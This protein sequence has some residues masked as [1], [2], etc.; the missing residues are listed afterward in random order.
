MNKILG[1]TILISA[2]LATTA[3]AQTPY[4]EGQKAL[5]EQNWPVA[6]EQFQ[7]A[8]KA[9]KSNADAAMYWRAHA[10]YQA[11]RKAEAERQIVA[12]ERKYPD[13][14]WIKQAQVLQIENQ[15]ADAIA[16]K[17]AGDSGLD[18][19]LR[20]FAL[21]QLMDR[22]PERAIPLVLK[23]LRTT[24]NEEIANDALFVLGM[25]DEP[26]AQ[27]AI[28]EVAHDSS[29]P[30]LQANAIHILGA[31]ST[32][33]SLELL[34]SL[35]SDSASFEVKQSIIQAHIVADE[36]GFLVEMLK[37]E[38]DAE[39]QREMIHALGIMDAT[40]QLAELYPTLT[41]METRRAALEAFS[42]A[43]DTEML[44]QVLATESE[45]E[46]RKA[47]IQGL[48]MEGGSESADYL[49]S[50]YANAKS[51]E[52][53]VDILES[54][55]MMDAAESFALSVVRTETDPE[56]QRHAI[57]VLGI[58][59]ATDELA[60]LYVN[61]TDKGS[62]IAV[63]ESMGISD[64]SRG[65][66]KILE[67]EKDPELREAAIQGL[68]INGDKASVE[69]LSSMY[70]QA[71]AKEKSAIVHSMLI[72][73]DVDGL[74][75]LLKQETDPQMKREM[76]EVLTMMD[77]EASDEYLFDLLENQ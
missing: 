42:I 40:D 60:D 72:M 35:Y 39:L 53:K 38:E 25:S 17:T 45:P 16:S 19:D 30:E 41:D 3:L 20:I 8:I 6:A 27:K 44:M 11:G 48:A 61:L 15:S 21:A 7:Q 23:V 69:Y 68:A 34:Q 64:D 50:L 28:S 37:Q 46:L 75:A 55:V 5:R 77:S 56:L 66:I 70:A 2:M 18:E 32:K 65:L 73:D 63:L 10:L 76:L 9:D 29:N 74:I 59:D 1:K 33:G 13:S 43:D 31:A 12:L 57:Q 51:T 49:Q 62:R 36:T 22:D 4:D 24:N 47:A 54:L 52:E 67:V 58:M 71:P 14:R 26:A